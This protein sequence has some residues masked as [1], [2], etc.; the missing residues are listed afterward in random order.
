MYLFYI[1]SL[2]PV[3]IG[4]VLW[5][6]KK[7]IVWKEWLAS[8]VIAFVTAGIMHLIVAT[9]LLGDTETWSGQIYST[10]FYPEWVEKY[11]QMHTRTVGSGKNQRIETYYTTEYRTHH[12]HWEARLNFG[13]GAFT[14][15]DISKS[16]YD[17]IRMNFGNKIITAT[18][19]KSGFVRGDKHVYTV[20]NTTKY[21]Y[22]VT[23]TQYFENRVKAAPNLFQFTT[24][25]KDY[26]VYPYPENSYWMQ[27][28]RLV[29]VN[30][31]S[32]YDWDCLNAK[33]GPFKLVNLIMIKF[34]KG[35]DR[36]SALYQE[37]A[38]IGGKKNDLVLCYEGS[39]T[40]AWSY[41]FGWT[42]QEDCKRNLED[43]LLKNKVN[44]SIL[45]LIEKEVALH[46]QIK[47]WH[48]FD[49]ISIE[50]PL[51]S[52]IVFLIVLIVTQGSFM[53]WA[54]HNEFEKGNHAW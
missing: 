48:K 42:E 35:A 54:Y 15:K 44:K 20:Y 46:Y 32:I 22:P 21:C 4:A 38:W 7:Q 3:S 52:Y 49:Y 14:D 5:I 40:A 34:D 2:L 27:S 43:I 28:N 12:E 39:D 36:Q 30:T 1:L 9:S 24:V 16:L 29:N 23:A 10:T 19:Y 11:L 13:N 18:P 41:V 31:I 26:K 45:P 25:P 50:P 37:A 33:L 53:W 47:D 51:W 8:T 17:E 6:C